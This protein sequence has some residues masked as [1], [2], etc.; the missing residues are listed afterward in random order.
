MFAFSLVTELRSSVKSW[1]YA[2][3]SNT[4]GSLTASAWERSL[5]GV[6]EVLGQWVMLRRVCSV[7]GLDGVVIEL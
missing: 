4:V 3:W 2:R 1:R 5:D 6:C 7:N